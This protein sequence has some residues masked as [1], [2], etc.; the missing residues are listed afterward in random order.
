M[1]SIPQFRRVGH[2]RVVNKSC[3]PP[4][5]LYFTTATSLRAMPSLTDSLAALADYS[6][7]IHTLAAA[8]QAPSG[9]Y[10]TAYL[11]SLYPN[12]VPVPGPST[13]ARPSSRSHSRPSHSRPD[14]GSV[15]SL[16]RDAD[17]NEKKLFR[18]VGETEVV[19]VG[20]V[21]RVEKRDEGRGG[22]S[23]FAGRAGEGERKERDEVEIMLKTALRLVDD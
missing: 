1:H 3:D 10:T 15:T 14:G 6:H 9:R 4:S 19:G 17:E 16:I 18:F 2:R 11:N 23:E 8:N 22:G 21:K 12:P 20:R 5:S 13:R 7:Q